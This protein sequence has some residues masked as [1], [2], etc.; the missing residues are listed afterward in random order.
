MFLVLTL[1][2]KSMETKQALFFMTA[3]LTAFIFLILSGAL[4]SNYYGLFVRK[5]PTGFLRRGG[6]KHSNH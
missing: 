1:G 4:Y 5:L 3:F 6:V 2:Y